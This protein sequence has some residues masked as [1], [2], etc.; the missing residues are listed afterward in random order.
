MEK[1]MLNKLM[2]SAKHA[3]ELGSKT[4]EG[5]DLSNE[6]F[7]DQAEAQRRLARTQRDTSPAAINTGRVNP[8]DFLYRQTLHQILYWGQ[9]RGNRTGT[10]ARS[11]FGTMLKFDLRD[12][13]FP[14]LTLRRL[15]FKSIA[16]ELI[17]FIRGYTSAAQFRTLGTSIW[18]AN[19]NEND[20]W[21]ENPNR[22]GEDDLG[23]VYGAQWRDW[24][25]PL[26]TIPLVDFTEIPENVPKDQIAAV[27]A[28]CE[29][30][31]ENRP[32]GFYQARTDQFKHLLHCLRNNRSDRRMIVSAWNPGELDHMAL[33]PCH[34]HFQC[35]VNYDGC[36][37]LC[38]YQ[39]SVD[40]VL[41][42]P[43]NI[44]SY[45]LLMNILCGLVPNLKLGTLTAMWGDYHIYHNH[46]E[47]VQQILGRNGHKPPSITINWPSEDV[48]ER[49]SWL[50]DELVN[51][52]N[53]IELHDYLAE[54]SIKFKMAV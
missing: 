52:V 38:W 43:F 16:A 21:L 13:S 28:W 39:R 54:P 44:A 46:F 4:A 22:K 3:G 24:R 42:A 32:I 5:G 18:D 10:D 36:L 9:D 31:K 19:A 49:W 2:E 6:G 34:M 12:G 47:G 41:G 37:D 8:H 29:D 27:T 50:N 30:V 23:R 1:N 48:D 7:I 45:A 25:G 11:C 51:P 20:A 40:T 33:P 53:A 15:P 14:L 26:H 35:Y 17:G